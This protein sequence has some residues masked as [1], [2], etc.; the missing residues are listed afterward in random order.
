MTE[1]TIESILAEIVVLRQKLDAE[2]LLIKAVLRDNVSLRIAALL[3]LFKAGGRIAITS[4]E[5]E[6]FTINAS[7][8]E[9]GVEPGEQPYGVIYHLRTRESLDNAIKM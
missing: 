9:V 2:E 6:E 7:R 5:M 4:E 1:D 8:L 3:M